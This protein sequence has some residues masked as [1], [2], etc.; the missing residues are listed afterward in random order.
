MFTHRQ[1]H[2]HVH[3]CTHVHALTRTRA[4]THT[5]THTYNSKG[6]LM[7]KWIDTGNSDITSPGFKVGKGCWNSKYCPH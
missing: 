1:T 6:A 2:T 3:A 5:H 7:I 4:H